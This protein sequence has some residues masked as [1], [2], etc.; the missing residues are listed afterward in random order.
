MWCAA[1]VTWGVAT[2]A[3]MGVA[4]FVP[5]LLPDVSRKAVGVPV[6]AGQ[7]PGGTAA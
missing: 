4:V 6:A 3:G 2:V 5:D 1:V 7:T